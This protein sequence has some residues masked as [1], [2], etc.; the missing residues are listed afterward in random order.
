[1]KRREPGGDQN[2]DFFWHEIPCV[3]EAAARAEAQRQQ[4]LEDPEEAE[5]I[6]LRNKN[7]EWVARRVPRHLPE[8]PRSFKRKL[9]DVIIENLHPENLLP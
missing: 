1:M 6:Y 5:W 9:M 4:A 8:K 3:N 2:L 7:K